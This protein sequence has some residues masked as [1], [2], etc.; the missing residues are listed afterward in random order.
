MYGASEL[1]T[2]KSD[3]FLANSRWDF[4]NEKGDPDFLEEVE[5]NV[6]HIIK[7]HWIDDA[8]KNLMKL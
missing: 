7:N 6:N 3:R 4:V 8:S 1:Y 2:I 5:G